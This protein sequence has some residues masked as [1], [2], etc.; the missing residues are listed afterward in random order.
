MA[1]WKEKG[2]VP[3]SDDDDD[4]DLDLDVDLGLDSPSHSSATH[5]EVATG[6]PIN[7]EIN[8]KINEERS[9]EYDEEHHQYVLQNG[10]NQQEDEGPAIGI[11]PLERTPTDAEHSEDRGGN[12]REEEPLKSFVQSH[13]APL[14]PSPESPQGFKFPLGFLDYDGTES[15]LSTSRQ[16]DQVSGPELVVEDDI[17]QTYVRITSPSSSPLTTPPSSQTSVRMT[18]SRSTQNERHQASENLVQPIPQESTT[19]ERPLP[20]LQGPPLDVYRRTFRQRNLIQLHPYALEEEKYRRTARARGMTPLRLAQIQ[21]EKNKKARD[22][23]S[24]DPDSQDMEFEMEESQ[25]MDV[26]WNPPSSPPLLPSAQ[27]EHSTENPNQAPAVGSDDE[28]PDIEE[29]LR[30]PVL[31]RHRADPKRRVKTYTSKPQKLRLSKIPTQPPRKT[32]SKNNDIFDVPAS[33]PATSSPFAATSHI[34]RASL[35]RTLSYSSSKESTP[36]RL[37]H[38]EPRFHGA[39]DLPTPAT[40]AMKPIPEPVFIDSDSDLGDPFG[41]GNGLSHSAASSSAESV[42]VRKVGKKIRGVL[43]ASHLRLDQP[44]RKATASSRTQRGSFSVSPAKLPARRGVAL[45]RPSGTAG[46]PSAATHSGIHFLSDDSDDDEIDENGFVMEDDRVNELDQLFQREGSADEDD[47]IDPMLPSHKRQKKLA[48]GNLRKRRRLDPTAVPRKRGSGSVRQ[49]KITEHLKQPR[50]STKSN[51]GQL[52]EGKL[53]SRRAKLADITRTTKENPPRLSILDVTDV[54]NHSRSDIPQFVRIA[55]RTARLKPGQG[56]Q[57]PSKKYIRLANRE[58]TLDAQSVLEDWR[59]GKI[60]PRVLNSLLEPPV[61][62]MRRPLNPIA[63]NRQTRLQ[64]PMSKGSSLDVRNRPVEMPR[65]IVVSR[66]KQR[67]MK[68]SMTSGEPMVDHHGAPPIGKRRAWTHPQTRPDK[69]HRIAPSARPAQLEAPEMDCSRQN[70][71]S[72][73]KSTKKTLDAIYRTTRKRRGPQVNLQLGRFL[74]DDDAVKSRVEVQSEVGETAVTPPAQLTLKGSRRSKPQPERIDVGAARYRQPSEPMILEVLSPTLIQHVSGE[75]SKLQG[76]GKFGTKYSLHFDIFPLQSGI[77]FHETTFIGSGRLSKAFKG[78]SVQTG[79][80]D[81]YTPIRL[82]ERAFRW[83]PWNQ[84][85]S[86][87]IGVCF[88]WIL[89]QHLSSSPASTPTVN[90]ISVATSIVDYVQGSLSFTD[91]D[92]HTDFLNRLIEVLQDV[93]SRIKS[94]L[95]AVQQTRSQLIEILNRSMLVGLRVLQVARA[96]PENAALG[97]K[98]EDVLKSIARTCVGLLLAHG[99]DGLRKLYDDLQYLSFRERGIRHDH[100]AAESWVIIMRVLEAAHIPR[101]SFWDIVNQELIDNEAKSTN[102]ARIMEKL[103]YSMF[104]LL[105]LCEF[106]EFGI[107]KPGR[108]RNKSFDNWSLP[109]Q[110]LKKIF[111]LY[112]SNPRQ[113]PGFND[114]CRALVSRCHYLITVWSW[115]KCSGVIGAIFDFLASQKLAHLRNE[116]VYDSPRFLRELDKEPALEVDPDDRCFHIFLKIVAMAIKHMEKAGDIKSI[117]NLVARLLPNHDRQYPKEEAIHQREL[118]SL[119]NH[120][121]LLCTLFWAAPADHRPSLSLIQKLVIADRSHKEACLINIRAWENLARFVVTKS[122]SS[123]TY[124]PF[125]LWQNEFSAKL[126]QQYLGIESEVR[127]QAEVLEKTDRNPISEGLLKQTILANRRSTIETLRVMVRA[128]D[129]TVKTATSPQLAIQ[130]FNPELLC[131]ASQPDSWGPNAVFQQRSGTNKSNAYWPL[132]LSALVDHKNLDDLKVTGFDIGLEW[133][134]ALS[135]SQSEVP[136]ALDMVNTLT[137]RLQT[138]AHYLAIWPHR[139]ASSTIDSGT[140]GENRFPNHTLFKTAVDIMRTTLLNQTNVDLVFGNKSQREACTM[141]SL[142]LKEVMESMKHQLE[143][144]TPGSNKLK[145]YVSFVQLIISILRSYASEIRPTLDFFSQPSAHYWPEDADPN[146]F[147]A[148]IIS[149]SLRLIEHPRRT[150]PILFHYLYSGWRK[151]LIQCRVGRHM[152]YVKK[153]MKRPEFTHFLMTEFLPA[154]LHVGFHSIGGWVLCATYLPVLSNR[155]IKIFQKKDAEAAFVFK[156]LV[157]ILRIILNGISESYVGTGFTGVDLDYQ[158]IVSATCQFWLS[159]DLPMRQYAGPDPE[160]RTLVGEVTG[161]LTRFIF[162]A[163]QPSE[164]GFGPVLWEIE[165]LEVINGD[166]IESFVSSITEDIKGRWEVHRG[167]MGADI[168]GTG[169][170]E[171]SKTR[172][173]FKQAV[174]VPHPLVRILELALPTLELSPEDTIPSALLVSADRLLRDVYF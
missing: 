58:D 10:S 90:T 146:L 171:G 21:D 45:P 117:R 43:P 131:K 164:D 162:Q 54:N 63:S 50:Q 33:P 114:Y 138:K 15:T 111:S 25:Q 4:L 158:A 65:K 32:W 61:S 40:S 159:V 130:A 103:W 115:W 148:G 167:N 39:A 44:R 169:A 101:G 107:V 133:L 85:V 31:A 166:H 28:F 151:D 62:V 2:E 34:T 20:P 123:V 105:P 68:N 95:S 19:E 150:S 36:A 100:F 155:I 124:Q 104:S 110:M 113:S 156:H 52:R 128:M 81:Q 118:A 13:E 80:L 24:P 73:F 79:A 9:K 38:D 92:D 67:S 143:I 53:S 119:R 51:A 11:A 7:E 66:V 29:L 106:D 154:A 30:A 99:L 120:H 71:A 37:E 35:S 86:S 82:G 132:F 91:S 23:S 22:A 134:L 153:G 172:V 135:K 48:G 60:K 127:H 102:D 74:A 84:V 56:K 78:S 152:N 168:G 8:E 16:R 141:F 26:D 47:R 109:Q 42:Q 55:A 75:G 122:S 94:H 88:D 17:S 83:G 46:S 64:S 112:S 170:H 161:P 5:N 70:P 12:L 136:F 57:S 163:C 27:D 3:D 108:R 6:L 126:Y 140:L 98:V 157:N 160:K 69:S 139:V 72:A 1:N 41:T 77:Y 173:D 49:P 145:E 87:E 89:D 129:Y 59:G 142:M 97:F 165:R 14:Q 174:G 96:R 18:T 76:L 121:D 149:Y 125:A 116:E 147:A 144:M 137:T 93:S